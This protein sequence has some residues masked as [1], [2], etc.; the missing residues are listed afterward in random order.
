VRAKRE[1]QREFPGGPNFALLF[2]I[3][4]PLAPT[5]K[6]EMSAALLS[7]QNSPSFRR[8][9]SLC[10]VAETKGPGRGKNSALLCFAAAKVCC[11]GDTEMVM[12]MRKIG[13]R[14]DDAAGFY[15]VLTN[16]T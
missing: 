7:D 15:F 5:A 10:V 12:K 9:R 8:R 6:V 2:S 16:A 3:S 14:V 11:P 4:L 13:C 1:R